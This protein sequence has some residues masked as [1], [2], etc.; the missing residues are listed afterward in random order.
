[1]ESPDEAVGA[2]LAEYIFCHRGRLRWRQ[3]GSILTPEITV[4]LL[5][6]ADRVESAIDL[7]DLEKTYEIR[8]LP[9]VYEFLASHGYLRPQLIAV[10]RKIHE[11]FEVSGKLILDLEV[12]Y[13]GGGV[14]GLAIIITVTEES[15]DSVDV[16]ERFDRMDSE[17]WLDAPEAADG[18]LEIHTE[19]V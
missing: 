17:W 13:D 5:R 7:A 12:E 4:I 18:I 19:F 6:A 8:D 3:E 14:F 16:L 9:A 10:A 15:D 11:F 1:M 2:R